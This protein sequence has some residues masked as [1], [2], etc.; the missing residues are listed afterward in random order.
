MIW[1][2]FEAHG[3]PQF[4]PTGQGIGLMVHCY[5]PYAHLNPN[6]P[7]RNWSRGVL[8]EN[9]DDQHVTL[10]GWWWMDTDTAAG[11]KL[12]APNGAQF[13]LYTNRTGWEFSPVHMPP[14]RIPEWNY[15]GLYV[16]RAP[17]SGRLDP[18]ISPTYTAYLLAPARGY[19]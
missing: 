5:Y 4:V 15:T 18:S 7:L 10:L 8:H 9:C 17:V 12:Y 11:D 13:D 3:W 6:L 16:Y 19:W 2:S 1:H 14:Q